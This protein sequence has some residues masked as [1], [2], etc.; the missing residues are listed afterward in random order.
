MLGI[1]VGPI[2]VAEDDDIDETRLRNLVKL[3]GLVEKLL[4]IINKQT[5][6]RYG[7][8]SGA[9]EIGICATGF[10]NSLEEWAP[11]S[12][13]ERQNYEWLEES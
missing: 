13:F 7:T 10:I 1:I 11:L 5:M 2:D 4:G 8:A 9:K 6:Y 3:I 12:S